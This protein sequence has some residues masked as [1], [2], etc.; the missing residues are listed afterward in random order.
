MTI[1]VGK[2]IYLYIGTLDNFQTKR[3]E[4]DYIILKRPYRRKLKNDEEKLYK[5]FSERF[6]R[7]DVDKLVIDYS[8]ISSLGIKIISVKENK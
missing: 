2:E 5:E 8:K 4:L 7:I 1:E 6:Y 3:D